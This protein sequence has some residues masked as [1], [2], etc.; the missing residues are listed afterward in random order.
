MGKLN[1]KGPKPF[2]LKEGLDKD[3]LNSFLKFA[4]KEL[5][6]K[7]LPS[8]ITLSKNTKKARERHTFGTF[9]PEN[10]SIW[11]YT[12]NRNTADILRT[13]AHELVHRK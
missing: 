13:L 7:Q 9:N 4:I 10:K 6:L 5:G 12:N 3:T 1:V 11:L 2:P 8:K